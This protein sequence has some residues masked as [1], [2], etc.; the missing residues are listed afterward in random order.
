MDTVVPGVVPRPCTISAAEIS[1][2]QWR[3]VVGFPCYEVSSLGRVRRIK[4]SAKGHTSYVGRVLKP[5]L[6]DGRPTVWFYVSGKGRPKRVHHLVLEAFV[7]P[8][9]PDMECRHLDGD[10]QNNRLTNLCWGT[11][12]ENEKDKLRHGTRLI[13]E[14]SP[15]AVLSIVEVLEI[16]RMVAE[17]YPHKVVAA[18]FGIHKATVSKIWLRT[19]WAHV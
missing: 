1:R 3:S 15:T 12:T 18:R 8:R 6:V 2:E 13:G 5:S 14:R 9:P 19:R 11:H 17:G 7:G 16:R 4:P 10:Q